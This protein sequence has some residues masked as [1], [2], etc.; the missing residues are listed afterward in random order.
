MDVIEGPQGGMYYINSK[1]NR[2]RLNRDGTKPW[3]NNE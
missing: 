3:D 2:T 1:G